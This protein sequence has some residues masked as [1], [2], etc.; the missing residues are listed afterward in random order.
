MFVQGSAYSMFTII[1]N[2]GDVQY[3][4][5]CM[6]IVIQLV[7]CCWGKCIVSE[8]SVKENMSYLF[9]C[10]MDRRHIISVAK[11]THSEPRIGWIDC[12]DA[13]ML[14]ALWTICVCVCEGVCPLHLRSAV[15]Q[16]VMYNPGSCWRDRHLS[17]CLSICLFFCLPIQSH[18]KLFLRWLL[19]LIWASGEV[20]F[21]L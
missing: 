17:I 5:S 4:F 11:V 16:M 15:D 10:I 12:D 19:S 7:K 8:W 21:A 13:H 6:V 18:C 14:Q 1:L 2:N 20:L 3:A 9:G